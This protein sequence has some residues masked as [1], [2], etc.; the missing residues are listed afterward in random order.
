MNIVPGQ[1]S[2]RHHTG[3]FQQSRNLTS[4]LR[5][6]LSGAFAV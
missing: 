6:M 4:M 2:I 5:R 3:L 1:R